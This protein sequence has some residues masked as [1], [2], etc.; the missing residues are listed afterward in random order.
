[1]HFPHTALLCWG[2]GRVTLSSGNGLI[3]ACDTGT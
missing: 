3:Q 2:A 1:M